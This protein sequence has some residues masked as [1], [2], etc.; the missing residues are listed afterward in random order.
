MYDD[1]LDF[2]RNR[3]NDFILI[4][5]AETSK[6]ELVYNKTM[7]KQNLNSESIEAYKKNE[8]NDLPEQLDYLLQPAYNYYPQERP[9]PLIYDSKNKKNT[10]NGK[11]KNKSLNKR[12]KN[13]STIK[14]KIPQKKKVNNNDLKGNIH[15][16]LN[17]NHNILNNP[18]NNNTKN[19]NFSSN[20][21]GLFDPH[22]KKNELGMAKRQDVIKQERQEK[23]RNY[24]IKFGK[25]VEN[26]QMY[27]NVQDMIEG[28]ELFNQDVSNQKLERQFQKTEIKKKTDKNI[29]INEQE[30]IRYISNNLDFNFD[31]QEEMVKALEKQIENERKLRAV[32]IY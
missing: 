13:S 16:N 20:G 19:F 24:N 32:I 5:N 8:Q 10:K 14:S 2:N 30:K 28:I 29:K 26:I 9:C 6:Q 21:N 17:I 25:K 3:L 1:Q 4:D 31:K 22:L 18:T 12:L 15:I 27:S 11:K 23:I 7:N